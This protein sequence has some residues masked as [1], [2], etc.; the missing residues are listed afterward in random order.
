MGR[1]AVNVNSSL[2]GRIMKL[3][4]LANMAF[5]EANIRAGVTYDKMNEYEKGLVDYI[6]GQAELI[7]AAA[8][9]KKPEEILR[10]IKDLKLP[11]AEP[12]V[13]EELEKYNRLTI[14]ALG[15]AA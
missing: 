6:K 4:T 8:K 3:P 1:G 15:K 14:E 5:A 7:T 10:F 12:L 13:P 9:A 2:E 11:P